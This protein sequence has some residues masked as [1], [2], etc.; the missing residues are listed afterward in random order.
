MSRGFG[1]PPGRAPNP[2]A[3]VR[4]VD[5]D[6][7]GMS[8]PLRSG[9]CLRAEHDCGPRFARAPFNQR[10]W[11]TPGQAARPPLRRRACG[12]VQD[13]GGVPFDSRARTVVDAHR[14]TFESLG[15]I[16]DQA[17]P[18]FAAAES[19]FRILRAWNRRLRTASVSAST[20]DGFK[21][22]LTAEIQEGLR[23]TA[24]DVARAGSGPWRNSGDASRHSSKATNTS[25][26]RP[27]NATR[28]TSTRP[29][30]LKSPASS[31]RT[32]ST[33]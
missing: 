30:R 17:E 11:R 12:R 13:L 27:R 25:C 6:D 21:D 20:P 22:T 28:L 31:S 32:T 26:C 18:D 16:V 19:A 15:C 33:G 5:A 29:T 1:L 24:T 4:V 2:K 7:L 9:P 10:A 23:L 14:K 8:G 3:P